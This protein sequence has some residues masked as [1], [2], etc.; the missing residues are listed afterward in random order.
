MKAFMSA[1][2]VLYVEAET[3]VEAYALKK[4][5][6]EAEY[7]HNMATQEYGLRGSKLITKGLKGIQD[8]QTERH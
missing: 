7:T 8:A 5:R 3:G 1:D 6:E 2:G 4:W